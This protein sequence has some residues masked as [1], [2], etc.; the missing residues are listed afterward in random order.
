MRTTWHE[1]AADPAAAGIEEARI[2]F[3]RGA[4]RLTLRAG[5]TGPDLCAA[6]FRGPRPAVRTDGAQITITY[7]RVGLGRPRAEVTLSREAAWEIVLGGVA[8][9]GADL[10]GLAL[11]GLGIDGGARHVE[12]SLPGPRG[13][14]PI[15]IRGGV[16]DLVLHRPAGTAATL[17]VSGGVR[18][19]AFAGQSFGAVGGGLAL[20]TPGGA[21][22]SDRYEITVGGGVSGLRDLPA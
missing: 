10:T 3:P 11:R 13:V 2:A 4:G 1:P 6:R 16:S 5:A 9:M 14:V 8:W 15:R 21:D 22:A 20:S 12:L 19:L 7:P 17:T 18:R